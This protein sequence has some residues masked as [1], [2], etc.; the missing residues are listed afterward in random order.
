MLRRINRLR[1]K[2]EINGAFSRGK[3]V[4]EGCLVLKS[5]ENQLN[6][7]RFCFV[8]SKR[9]S[10]T[11]VG[12]NLLKRRM[13]EIARAA[14]PDLKPGY[15]LILIAMPGLEKEDYSSI[16]SIMKKSFLRSGI[17]IGDKL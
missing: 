17:I 12:R 8:V 2:K 14:L 11:A 10:K 4:K 3:S 5:A 15:D 6:S 13:R 16:E 7:V 1:K 9:V